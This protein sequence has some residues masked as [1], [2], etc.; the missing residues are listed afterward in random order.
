MTTKYA[1]QFAYDGSGFCGWQTQRSIGRHANPSP[2]IE[3]KLV[4]AVREVSGEE[5]IV[6]AS[7]RTDAGV[8]A[9]GQV[10]HFS[11]KFPRESDEYFLGGLNS[12]L[13]DTIRV[14]R[15]G[16]VPGDFRAQH[17]ARK[18]Y[19]YYFQQGVANLPHLRSYTMWNRHELDSEKMQAALRH[20][21]GEHDF[22]SF[23]GAGAKVSSTVRQIFEADVT[24]EA[25]P[26]PG[27]F[28]PASQSLIRVRL[29]G[30]GFLKRMVR[31]IAGTLKQIGE[32]RR[33]P[34]EMAAILASGDREQVGPTAPASGLWL[35]RVWYARQ[36]G[37]DFLHQCDSS[38]TPAE[39]PRT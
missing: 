1:I 5:V 3:E 8:H 33:S 11:L 39:S 10:A 30:S 25:V 14:H 18:Q 21:I 32:G 13:P 24:R 9:S 15:L 26:Q 27:C 36:E 17:A 22:R 20:L 7:G 34:D 6:V 31:G 2:S 4:D 12:Q 28:D 37:I 23:C 35:D 38:T 29:V 19:S 16:Q